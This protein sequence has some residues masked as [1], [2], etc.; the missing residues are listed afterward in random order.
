MRP[1]RR[2][3]RQIAEE[4]LARLRF[5]AHPPHGLA[6]EHVGRVAGESAPPAVVPVGVVEVIVV[7]EIR[8]GADVRRRIPER[9]VKAPVL[10][11]IGII[12][13]QMPFAEDAGRVAGGGEQVGHRRQVAAEQR[14]SAGDV[15]RAVAQAIHARHELA[16]R[17][18][19][20]RRDMEVRE[21]DALGVQPVE[22]RRL[23]HRI[24]VNGQLAVALVIG[25]E[26]EDVGQASRNC[27]GA[28]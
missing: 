21:P 25:D 27:G 17:G 9:L 14:A 6:E 8:R 16:A 20:H 22:M 5:P 7:P 24:P 4:A 19:T 11:A 28:E 18:R 2:G 13:A 26:D 3:G 1:V 10:R 12:V 15:H 23:Q